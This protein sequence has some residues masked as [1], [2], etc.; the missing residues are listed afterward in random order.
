MPPAVAP[1]LAGA[2]G[3][4]GRRADSVVGTS[5]IRRP[6][7]AASH[8]H[9]AGEL[10]AGGAQAEAA[11]RLRRESRAGRSGSRRSGCWK[12]SRPEEAE[13]P[14]CRGSGAASGM[15]PGRDAALEAVAHD[16]VGAAAQ[17]G[18]GSAS[19]LREVVA[20]VGVAHDDVAAAR[21]ARSRRS[22]RRRSPCREPERP[23]R[24]EPRRCICD[25]SVLP[26]SAIR[27]SPATVC[28]PESRWP[29]SMQAWP[30]F[31][32]VQA[33][34]QDR[35]LASAGVRPALCHVPCQTQPERSARVSSGVGAGQVEGSRRGQPQLMVPSF[36]GAAGEPGTQTGDEG[37]TRLGRTAPDA[38]GSARLVLS[39]AVRKDGV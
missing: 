25:P 12:N 34:H 17:L 11:D 22:A 24:R 20:V 31:G 2:A 18:R 6:A 15:A 7:M 39:H 30:G 38:L 32:F 9:F 21:R 28:S 3:G 8:H 29:C 33:R 26:L 23:G 13:A 36:R 27:T 16:E 19:R 1:G 14:D 10:H 5:S 35:Q 37:V 4:C